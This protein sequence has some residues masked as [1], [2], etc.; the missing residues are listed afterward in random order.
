MAPF[1]NLIVPTVDST[2]IKYIL[3]AQVPLRTRNPTLWTLQPEAE[4]RNS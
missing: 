2:R 3:R 4:P 1:F